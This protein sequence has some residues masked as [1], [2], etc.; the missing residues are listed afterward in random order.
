MLRVSLLVQE[1][2]DGARTVVVVDVLGESGM[3]P[4]GEE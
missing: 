3:G 1:A 2:K 4:N